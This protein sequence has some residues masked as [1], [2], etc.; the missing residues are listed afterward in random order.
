MDHGVGVLVLL[1][2]SI[3][4]EHNLLLRMEGLWSIRIEIHI[5]AEVVL[6]LVEVETSIAE[7]VDVPLAHLWLWSIIE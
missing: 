3:V 2:E 6:F 7:L 4:V 1:L 5:Q